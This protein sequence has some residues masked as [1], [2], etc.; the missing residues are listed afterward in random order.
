MMVVMYRVVNH[1]PQCY[2]PLWSITDSLASQE[3][4]GGRV[5]SEVAS[6]Q[7]DSFFRVVALI[8]WAYIVRIRCLNPEHGNLHSWCPEP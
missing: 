8:P 3:L 1:P 7:L 6:Q 4:H 2:L 5:S